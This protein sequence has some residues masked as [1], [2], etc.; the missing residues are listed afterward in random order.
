MPAWQDWSDDDTQLVVP[1]LSCCVL[2][3]IVG[4]APKHP[5]SPDPLGPTDSTSAL[6][7]LA[8]VDEDLWQLRVFFGSNT[9]ERVRCWR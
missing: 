2:Q 9:A 4:A 1:H 8:A 3:V 5:Q 7:Q 6:Q